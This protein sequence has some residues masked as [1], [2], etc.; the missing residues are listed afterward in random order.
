M[1]T[2]FLRS[3]D[4]CT[5]TNYSHEVWVMLAVGSYGFAWQHGAAISTSVVALPSA[6]PVG[7]RL[8][9]C[10]CSYDGTMILAFSISVS[11]VGE[12]GQNAAA[13]SPE[14][15]AT[16]SVARAVAAAYDVVRNSGLAHRLSSMFTEIEG[17]WDEVMGVLKQCVEAVEPF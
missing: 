3:T 12:L 9:S 15:A 1:L 6:L 7:R 4:G 2:S 5:L 11:G 17:D 8:H 14:D 10:R 16:G 13:N